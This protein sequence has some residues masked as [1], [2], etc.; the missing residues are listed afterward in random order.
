[1]SRGADGSLIEMGPNRTQTG[2]IK[3][4]IS[5]R[6]IKNSSEITIFRENIAQGHSL[7]KLLIRDDILDKLKS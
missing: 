6:N 1:M 3:S 7:S 2:N 4:N 5:L